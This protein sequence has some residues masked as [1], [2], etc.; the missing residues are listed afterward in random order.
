MQLF[1]LTNRISPLSFL[2]LFLSL[3]PMPTLLICALLSCLVIVNAQLEISELVRCAP[4]CW[5]FKE[6]LPDF[7]SFL[8]LGRKWVWTNLFTSAIHLPENVNTKHKPFTTISGLK[9]EPFLFHLLISSF[10]LLLFSKS[11]P[12]F[13]KSHMMSWLAVT[14][15]FLSY[16]FT[17]P[18]TH[19]FIPLSTLF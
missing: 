5:H 18:S 1:V 11:S 9:F 6:E 2:C 14:S 4:G 12:L 16:D 13:Y 19:S 15:Q 8:F 17:F 7:P 3:I 10:L